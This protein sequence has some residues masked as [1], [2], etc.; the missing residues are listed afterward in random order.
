MAESLALDGA[1]DAL[2]MVLDAGA[3]NLYQK[4][5]TSKVK[6]H[7]ARTCR[8][9]METIYSS[10]KM[11]RDDEPG[12]A[13]FA[14]MW[15]DDGEPAPAKRPEWIRHN[16]KVRYLP[17]KVPEVKKKPKSKRRRSTLKAIRMSPKRFTFTMSNAMAVERGD[18]IIN[19]QESPTS[20]RSRGNTSRV[21]YGQSSLSKLEKHDAS[22]SQVKLGSVR[23]SMNFDEPEDDHF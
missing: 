12:G 3:E 15:E 16:L 13:K 9:M 11:K 14:E 22:P 10:I 2:D 8:A 23:R 4:Y 5:L 7:S 21:D 20:I 1:F 18:G 6:A 17:P 19:I